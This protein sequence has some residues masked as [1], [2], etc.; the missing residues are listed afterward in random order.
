MSAE[1][2]KSLKNYKVGAGNVSSRAILTA[3]MVKHITGLSD[4]NT[5]KEKQRNP[6]Y[7]YL[8]GREFFGYDRLLDPSLFMTIRKMPT[9]EKSEPFNIMAPAVGVFQFSELDSCDS[10]VQLGTY[11]A[12][13]TV[14]HET[15]C[16]VHLVLFEY[17]LHI[18]M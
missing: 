3:A 8:A 6:D 12:D 16:P 7:Q 9:C 4:E 2:E 13:N 5:I 18:N 15:E 11:R 17:R 1:Y 14:R 10:V